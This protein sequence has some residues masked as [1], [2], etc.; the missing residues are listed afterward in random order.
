[1]D[2]VVDQKIILEIKAIEKVLPIN[3]AQLVTYLRLSGHRVGLIMNF[4]SVV[5]KEGLH[6]LVL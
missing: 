6:R 1:M 3:K 4:N 2:I 5:L